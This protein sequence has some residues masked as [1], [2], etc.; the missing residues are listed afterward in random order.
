MVELPS[1]FKDIE[2]IILDMDGVLTSE[3]AYWDAAGLVV[4]ELIESPAFLALSPP[5][6]TPVANIFYQRMAN[7]TRQ[8]WRKYLPP[9]LIKKCKIRGINS[10]WDL[11][12]VVAGLYLA[13]LFAPLLPALS[14]R[15]AADA[16]ASRMADDPHETRF[17]TEKTISSDFLRSSAMLK[18]SLS[19]IWDELQRRVENNAW[20][21]LL[22]THEFHLWGEFF[23]K[24]NYAITPLKHIELL[25]IDDFHPG[26]RGLRLLEELNRL[27]DPHSPA[28]YPVF[29]RNTPLWDECRDLFQ[30]WYLGEI[31][32]EEIYHRPLP[33][34]PKPGLIHKEEPL[35]GKEH[36]HQ[37]LTHL[38]DAGYHLGIATGRPRMEILTPLR[39][40]DML[41]YF[42]PDRISTYDEVEEA[43]A[44]L[45]QDGIA[46]NM[47]KPHP[48]VFLKSIEP[49][50][51]IQ[52]LYQRSEAF[53]P[54]RHQILIVGDAQADIW[55]A[56]KIGCH[57]AALLSGAIGP[58]QR[59][60]MEEAHPDVICN[61]LLE[62]TQAL[63][64]LQSKSI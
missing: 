42:D 4:R 64:A 2:L 27:L 5:N 24:Q 21:D 45:Q 22:H 26:V 54:Q 37:C 40:W 9:E 41:S 46:A 6:Y 43:E 3:Q 50:L 57:S 12:Y 18:D 23:R 55:A 49:H 33:Y 51:P 61:D 39:E 36:T 32:Y 58:S 17:T 14:K 10:N 60:A 34:S 29:G 44:T 25:I 1:R 7:G 52:S 47:G 62:L 56:Q 19:P 63:C 31:L 53:H 11:A 38:R 16:L 13:P 28:S 48:Y 8:D 35:H 30:G 20:A 59:K 15:T